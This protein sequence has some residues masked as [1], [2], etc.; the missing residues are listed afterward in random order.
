LVALYGFGGQITYAIN[1]NYFPHQTPRSDLLW[2][3]IPYCV[4]M[5]LAV[6]GVFL[7][8]YRTFARAG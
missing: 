1:A 6:E 5:M 3:Y 8:I 2:A 4:A 7:V